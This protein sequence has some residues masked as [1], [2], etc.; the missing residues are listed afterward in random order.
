MLE[1]HRVEELEHF[2]EGFAGLAGGDAALF[3]NLVDAVADGAEEL[4]PACF[5]RPVD[6]LGG[7]H[8]A[9]SNPTRRSYTYI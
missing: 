9:Q 3:E 7:R 6:P 1:L 4:A 8:A 2:G 5:D